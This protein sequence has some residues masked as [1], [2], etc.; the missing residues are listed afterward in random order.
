MENVN[1]PE[2]GDIKIRKLSK[3]DWEYIRN[4]CIS[5]DLDTKQEK[6]NT[7]SFYKYLVVLGVAE[8]PFFSKPYPENSRQDYR[9]INTRVEEYYNSDTPQNVMD[10]IANKIKDYNTINQKEIKEVSKK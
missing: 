9:F 3:R 8:A 7:G 1:I 4:E 2:V 5:V 10:V 6:T